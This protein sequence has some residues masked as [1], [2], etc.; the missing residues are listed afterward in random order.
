MIQINTPDRFDMNPTWKLGY[1]HGSGLEGYGGSRPE[2]IGQHQRRFE[3]DRMRTEA[4]L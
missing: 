1:F 2:V 3:Y 4:L